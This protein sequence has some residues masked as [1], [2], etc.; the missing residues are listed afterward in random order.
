MQENTNFWLDLYNKKKGLGPIIALAPMADVTDIVFRNLIAE[1]SEYGTDNCDLDVFWTEFV[2]VNGL[3]DPRGREA[4]IK[5]LKYEE[6]ER[7][8]VAQIFGDRVDGFEN[9]TNLLVELGFDGVDIN[10]GCPDNNVIGQGSGSYMIKVPELAKE[11]ATIVKNTLENTSISP[12][13]SEHRRGRVP[14][15]IKTRIG[16]NIIEWQTWLEEILKVKP[17]VLTIHLRTKKEMSLVSAHWELAPEIVKWIRENFG[18]PETGGPIIILNGDVK[19]VAEATEKW[20]ASGC[21]GIM[22]GRGIFGNPWLFN[23][24]IKKE[25]LSLKEILNT[26]VEH[27]QRFEKELS[28]KS[29]AIMKKHFK[30]YVHGFDGAKELRAKLMDAKN[31]KD[32]K[33][34][35][36]KFLFWYKLKSFFKF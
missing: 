19:N 20:R 1:K 23:K 3:N 2:S 30:A 7:P 9:V 14:M 36:K 22:I 12:N 24:K 16:Y 8:I 11:I 5:D 35:I 34:T 32:V 6:K 18:Y 33:K 17:V 13:L 10:M 27:S 31:A 28:F 4:L 26:L 25:D 21:D 15:S 29:F